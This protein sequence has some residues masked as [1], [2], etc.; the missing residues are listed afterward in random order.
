MNLKLELHS[1]D[2]LQSRFLSMFALFGDVLISYAYVVTRS[3]PLP[4][5]FDV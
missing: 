2:I 3:F 5:F 4:S 1:L